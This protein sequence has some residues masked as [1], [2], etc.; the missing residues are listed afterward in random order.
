MAGRFTGG[1]L[2]GALRY[3]A[4]SEPADPRGNTIYAGTLDD[5]SLFEPAIA[6]MTRFKPDWVILPD[7]T[8]CF[9][10]MRQ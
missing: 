1:C 4:A 2:R 7:G 9:E 3:E 10:G 5:P 8:T 6:I